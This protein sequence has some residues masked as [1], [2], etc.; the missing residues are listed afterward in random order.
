[1]LDKALIAAMHTQFL[2]RYAVQNVIITLIIASIYLTI[3]TSSLNCHC[4]VKRKQ[5]LLG[6]NLPG[7]AG[8][9]MSWTNRSVADELCSSSSFWNMPQKTQNIV[10]YI[11]TPQTL[12]DKIL[13]CLVA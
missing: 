1:M 2:G 7:I 8:T 13:C 6:S 5:A 11:R 4:P 9:K 10:H 12:V 3:T